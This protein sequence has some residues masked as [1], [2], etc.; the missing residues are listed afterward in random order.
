[1]IVSA[2]RRTDIAAFY[3]KWFMNRVRAG[4][5]LVP[6]PFNL[7]Q[8]SRVSLSPPEVEALVFW[9][10]NPAPLFEYLQEL[11][12][13]GLRY[14]FL[15]TLV[16]YPRAI[17]PGTPPRERSMETFQKLSARLGPE[18]TI[19]RYDPIVLSELTGVGFHERNFR[20]LASELRGA[21][22]RCIISFVRP[23]RKAR[24]RM[25]AAAAGSGDPVDCNSPQISALLG[26]MSQIARENRIQ[27][28][29]CASEHDF[30]AYDIHPS[31]C[32]DSELLARLFGIEPKAAK[33]PYQRKECG[34]AASR[35]IGMYDTCLFGCSYCYATSNYERARANHARHDPDSP[36]LLPGGK[37]GQENLK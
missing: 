35:D 7:N 17:D 12:D 13:C 30:S 9:S 29:S 5:C 1:M 15:F 4:W 24:L 27:L 26:H 33:D 28:F 23:Y 8:V 37:I 18:R 25:E 19:W 2:S 34:C 21:A 16:G 20:E 6:N 3:S 32:I 11:D 22:S 36:S 31:R 14:Y 10:R